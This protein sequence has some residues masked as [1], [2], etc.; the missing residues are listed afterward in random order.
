MLD[1]KNIDARATI[2]KSIAYVLSV[3]PPLRLS[4][5]S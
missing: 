4:I 3:L 5:L 1:H 2:L